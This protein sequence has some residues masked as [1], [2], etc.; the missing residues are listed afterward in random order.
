MAILANTEFKGI[1]VNGA[2]WRCESILVTQ[3]YQA[4]ADMPKYMSNHTIDDAVPGKKVGILAFFK[5]YA[6][7]EK[8]KDLMCE[9]EYKLSE[10]KVYV[11]LDQDIDITQNLFQLAYEFVLSEGQFLYGGTPT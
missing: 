4:S 9:K 3:T 1:A 2:Y 8:S 6:D 7:E 11:A 5:C 10:K